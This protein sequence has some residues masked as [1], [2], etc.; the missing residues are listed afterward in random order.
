MPP[1]NIAVGDRLKDNDKRVSF[2]RILTIE[3]LQ[4]AQDGT[5]LK[6]S[7]RQRPGSQLVHISAKRIHSD[8]KLRASGFTLL[9]AEPLP[10]K[11]QALL[12]QEFRLRRGSRGRTVGEGCDRIVRA[13]L[14]RVE[15]QMVFATLLE[16]DPLATAAPKK[17]GESGIWHGLSFI[18]NLSEHDPT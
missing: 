17:T 16:D 5:L 6:V 9:R 1:S 14:D 3:A 15:N 8:G 12:G 11:L 10:A 18:D 2:S 4:H 7:A 13:R